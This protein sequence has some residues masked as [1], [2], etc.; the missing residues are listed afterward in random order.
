MATKFDPFQIAL[1]E[2][3]L[4]ITMY[5]EGELKEK[6]KLLGVRLRLLGS[7]CLCGRMWL[8][9]EDCE[10][11]LL[12]IEET[13]YQRVLEI[14]SAGTKLQSWR[15]LHPWVSKLFGGFHQF[16]C[17]RFRDPD[18]DGDGDHQMISDAKTMFDR[19]RAWRSKLIGCIHRFVCIRLRNHTPNVEH[20][21]TEFQFY[22]QLLSF[23]Q[24]MD[25]LYHIFS[26]SSLKTVSSNQGILF[27]VSIIDSLSK[28]TL[29]LQGMM[30]HNSHY[31]EWLQ[32]CTDF[33]K[34]LISFAFFRGVEPR[35]ME[36]LLTH[37]QRFVVDAL[38]HLSM[39]CCNQNPQHIAQLS[40][41]GLR[42]KFR[43][44]DIYVAV[45]QASKLPLSYSHCTQ[46]D[47]RVIFKD[48]VDVLLTVLWSRL[49]LDVSS[50]YI[51]NRQMQ[52]LYGGLTFLRSIMTDQ[53]IKFDGLYEKMPALI[54]L[55]TCEAGITIIHT[56]GKGTRSSTRK[57][58]ILFSKTE[59]LLVTLMETVKEEDQQL[60]LAS[61]FPQTNLLGFID[62]LLE[63]M[64]SGIS[65]ST[66]CLSKGELQSLHDNLT[67]VRSSWIMLQQFNSEM[68]QV[69]RSRIA[70][71]AYETEFVLDS[72]MA[73]GDLDSF[74][75]IID[76]ITTAVKLINAEASESF[77][78]HNQKQSSV[79]AETFHKMPSKGEIQV[80][81]DGMVGLADEVEKIIGRLTRGTKQLDIVSIVGMPGLGKT[82]LAKEIY[83]DVSV[84]LQFH[85]HS[86]CTVSQVY[87]K[88]RL[89]L[90]ILR[91]LHIDFDEKC[92]EMDEDC[93]SQKLHQKL[94]GKRYLI[95][96]DDIWDIGAWHCLRESFPEGVLGSRILLT[97]RHH[98]VA[99]EIKPGSEPHN[100]RHL[101]ID[102]SQELLQKVLGLK[103]GCST[104]ELGCLKA[105]VHECSG[106]PLMVLIVAGLLS[107]MK[108]DAWEDVRD[109]L[110]NRT[111]SLTE[112][113][114]ETI[115]LSYSYLPDHLKECFLYI[116]AI[117]V[118]RQIPVRKLLRLWMAEGFVE[119]T[120]R[121]SS[122][123]V[124]WRYLMELIQRNLVMVGKKGS[125]GTIKSCVLHDLLRDLCIKKYNEDH[126]LHSLR[127]YDELGNSVNPS[128]SYRLC[129]FSRMRDKNFAESRLVCPRLRTLFIVADQEVL[130]SRRGYDILLRFKQSKLLRVLD[131]MTVNVGSCFPVVIELL[132]HLRYLAL[133][134][135]SGELLLPASF[136]NLSNLETF[137]VLISGY[138][139][140]P[141][142]LSNMKN[143]KHLCVTGLL[144]YWILPDNFSASE[145]LKTLSGALFHSDLRLMELMR[146]LPNIRRLRYRCIN[147]IPSKVVVSLDF[148]SQLESLTISDHQTG[149]LDFQFPRNLKKLT[150]KNLLLPWSKITAF[151]RLPNLE[152]LKLQRNAFTG[153]IWNMEK[154]GTFPKL[155]FLKLEDLDLAQWTDSENNFPCLQSLVLISCHRLEELPSCLSQIETLQTIEV[156][157]CE[158]VAA[159]INQVQQEQMGWGRE[160]LKIRMLSSDLGER[161]RDVARLFRNIG[162]KMLDVAEES[163][164][165]LFPS[166]RASSKSVFAKLLVGYPSLLPST[167][168]KEEV[169]SLSFQMWSRLREMAKYDPFQIAMREVKLI[170]AKYPDGDLKEN[171][172]LLGVRLRLLTIFCMCARMWV[173]GESCGS[174]LLRIEE[175]VY[176]QA[177]KIQATGIKFGFWGIFHS[178][179]SKLF[180]GIHQFICLRF[181]DHDDDGDDQMISETKSIL[182][183]LRKWRSKLIGRIHQSI[184][185][186]LSNN[187]AKLLHL[188]S[189]YLSFIQQLLFRQETE[190]LYIIFS[191]SSL[192]TISST[193]EVLSL[194]DVIYSLFDITLYLQGMNQISFYV[195]YLQTY[196]RFLKNLI[197]F[198]SLR[199]VGLRQ[200]KSLVNHTQLF[201]VDA[202]H[203]LFMLCYNQN[204]QHIPLL[205]SRG[206]PIGSPAYQIYVGVLR[207]SKL[208]LPYHHFTPAECRVIFEDFVDS[209]LALLWSLLFPADSSADIFYHQMQK[210]YG[211]L[212]FLRVT[213]IEQPNKFDELYEKMPALIGLLICEAG[214][215]TSYLFVK[216]TG[217]FAYKLKFL[218]SRTEMYFMKLMEAVK[219]EDKLMF[220]A[221]FPQTNLLGFTDRLL[222]KMKSIIT[223]DDVLSVSLLK[224]ELQTLHDNLTEMR[225]SLVMMSFNQNRK[226][227]IL[228][229]RIAAAVYETEFV[230][231]SFMVGSD[232]VCSV[233]ILGNIITELKLINAEASDIFH[234]EKQISKVDETSHKMPSASEIPVLD[235]RMVGL[236]DEVE[237][238]A[239]RLTR[240]TEHL[241][242]VS[243]VGMPGLGKTMLAK[244]V[245]QDR[246]IMLH[247]HV[248]SWC[249]ISQAYD[250]R[251]LL[252]EI[253]SGLGIKSDDNFSKIDEDDLSLKLYQ[254]LKGKRYLIILDDIWDT[255]AWHSLSSSFPNDVNGSRILLT[256]RHHNVAMEIK[257]D[258]E[259]HHLRFLHNNE[260]WELMQKT[261]GL[262]E[263]C[264]PEQLECMKEIVHDCSGLPLMILIVAGILS[265]MEP[266]TWDEVRESLKKGTLSLTE[267]CMETIELSYS[268]LPDHLKECFLYFGASGEDQEIPVRKLL[269]L[270]MAEGFTQTNGRDCSEHVAKSYMRELIHR[271]LV[272]VGKKGSRGTIK[273]CVVHDLLRDFCMKKCNEE[274]FLHHLHGY[275]VSNSVEPS[276]FYRLRLCY[277]TREDFGES[278]LPCPRLRTLFIVDD[279]DVLSSRHSFGI[280]YKFNQS[281]LLR[282]LDIRTA[283][284]SSSFPVIE[285]L[286]H[287]R[288][289]ALQ[290]PSRGFFLPS[291]IANLSNLETFIILAPST[292]V[293]P[294]TLWSMKNLRHLFVTGL[295]A[296]LGHW[297]L[298]D[299]YLE[300]FSGL[301]NLE[302]LSSV[303]FLSDLPMME[304]LRK[305]PN[306]R[307]LRYRCISETPSG[308]VALDFLSRL[309]SLTISD[310]HSVCDLNFRFPHTLRKLSL[311][312]LDL[313]WNKISI[314]DRL[315]NLE[316]LKLRN[317]AFTG[318]NWEMEEEGT[319]PML[320]F[321]TLE[322]L[323]LARWTDSYDN[324]PCLQKLILISCH[325]LE[326][327]PSCLA[328]SSTLETIEVINCK[329]VAASV[330][331]IQKEHMDMGNEDLDIQIPPS[332]GRERRLDFGRLFRNALKIIDFPNVEASKAEVHELE[333]TKDSS[334]ASSSSL[335]GVQQ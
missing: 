303:L 159:S 129:L 28:N 321:L 249:S 190:E 244:K 7:F 252:L 52:E 41:R 21:D 239:D 290:I 205:T 133:Q 236:D 76:K 42:I 302:T 153:E 309:E 96:L 106:L 275:E 289:L 189:E 209:L 68:F 322:D 308:I 136:A 293:L 43:A 216:E 18:D 30:I 87:T 94:L 186:R 335:Q 328:Q 2:V 71:I 90:D 99:S 224:D 72:F 225:S 240:G 197:V 295:L 111:L 137:N 54:G 48:F 120:E 1:N 56:F 149:D 283:F 121:E 112:K 73:G 228:R 226:V 287:L 326:E 258:R 126:F 6:A 268:F 260:S 281:K 45:L 207:A 273:S 291:S 63:K 92:S 124:A 208:S 83:N 169:D 176:Q 242:I 221:N 116:G 58:E 261:K 138:I 232:L 231:D 19:L 278:R 211:G 212:T 85:V 173:G 332:D 305:F 49:V 306:L 109:S 74:I 301:E 213:M 164:K 97:S 255:A 198:A 196:L 141:D 259:P 276:I 132:V 23:R 36:S 155:R 251:H 34:G 16:I 238:I 220:S 311:A 69:L 82:M 179:V 143:L 110:R 182:D 320:K 312:G 154:E 315:P 10:S 310:H 284:A 98:N 31:V 142:T 172:K 13:V 40:S 319:F 330:K 204:P 146:K 115:E 185:V 89:L 200:M 55:L 118:D 130:N 217:G 288:Y 61:E 279:N 127:G 247:F 78:F 266:N 171:A 210:L 195:E 51:F 177:M 193:Q 323:D 128:I 123:D 66:L 265:H 125:G 17:L 105:I 81:E 148:M 65:Y 9:G 50:A 139:V 331:Q 181:G 102:E 203:N 298:P 282:V 64:K 248:H 257:P 145:N 53:P 286:V 219:A 271:N 147:M 329:H 168:K 307:R 8:R 35:Q 57:L 234:D 280:L 91:G 318:D 264:S 235:D 95:I 67:D 256:S 62:H 151:D 294:D 79:V 270:W 107:S 285:T 37:S 39:F 325:N 313:P 108:P 250:K 229:S 237:K 187:Q 100:L 15:I 162:L 152:V 206:L 183:R 114:M 27:L 144:S 167:S 75:Q 24:E 80:L 77:Q 25:K 227:Q 29:H 327:L 150:L 296:E 33:L 161:M 70:A 299:N 84:I 170:V 103:E 163:N 316:V 333:N 86:W 157:N 12:S 14:Q 113:C 88:R 214:I 222:E 272:M 297:I 26:E 117:G 178:C 233:N 101:H 223:D 253:L 254:Q 334:S 160:D 122:E 188:H 215:T 314:C 201:I 304:V 156:I 230:F 60:M 4:I 246:S 191:D 93:L 241:D 202:V 32:A 165:K 277:R 11:T 119:K 324:F 184:C 243:I 274:H 199:G 194:L 20:L 38:H 180:G 269:C 263:G 245:Y 300:D 317:N 292:I 5:P 134:I 262:K 104:E 140:L 59:K 267:K 218:F 158:H 175:T 46:A 131:L 47:C 174:T 3:K 135:A 22:I 166:K 44:R 192:V